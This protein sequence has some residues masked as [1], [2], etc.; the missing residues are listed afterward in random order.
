M[1]RTSVTEVKWSF[2]WFE[3]KPNESFL[4]SGMFSTKEIYRSSVQVHVS[5]QMYLKNAI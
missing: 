1:Q 4:N 3:K 5:C 2:D